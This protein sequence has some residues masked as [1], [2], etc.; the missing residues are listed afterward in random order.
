MDTPSRRRAVGLGVGICLLGLCVLGLTTSTA[1]AQQPQVSDPAA[2][3][4]ITDIY[5]TNVS[6]G[7]SQIRDFEPTPDGGLIALRITGDGSETTVLRLD[8]DND[9]IEES[10]VP[11]R[12]VS[13]SRVD[14]DSYATTG[15]SGDNVVVSRVHEDGWVQWTEQYGGNQTDWGTDVVSAPHGDTYV[16]ATTESFETNNSDTWV[17]RLDEDGET[18][19]DEV[20]KN[21]KWTAFP[22]G[23]RLDDGSLIATTRTERSLNKSVDG[24][25]NISAVRLAPDGERTW[26]TRITGSA[27]PQN[28]EEVFE[29]IPAHDDGVLIAGASNSGNTL[30]AN[31]D[32]WAAELSSG[33]EVRWQ[34]QYESSQRSLAMSAVRT[35][36]GYL[37]AGGRMDDQGGQKLV[38]VNQD[39]SERF[40]VSANRSEEFDDRI[41]D[42]AWTTDG[43]LVV[44]GSSSIQ[45]QR[46]SSAWITDISSDFDSLEP[47]PS[48]WETQHSEAEKAGEG[49]SIEDS[50]ADMVLYALTAISVMLLLVPFGLRRIRGRR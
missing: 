31:F 29:V 50:A 46:V 34:R 18:R 41:Q 42:V 3:S 15:F 27:T 21:E 22:K 24:Q 17:L 12:H 9:V 32:F 10:T 2:G 35:S 47:G 1:V 5:S 11:G 8:G 7:L 30:G 19:W 36:D 37:L 4:N 20:V 33:G 38:A 44:G 26:E 23:E 48:T 45:S 49:P 25:Q 16:L 28:K 14:N 43:R 6:D 39:G 40:R 13:I